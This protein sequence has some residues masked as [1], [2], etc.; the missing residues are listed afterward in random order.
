[1]VKA[2]HPADDAEDGAEYARQARPR[3][4]AA[5]DQGRYE[6]RTDENEA[7]RAH[8]RASRNGPAGWRPINL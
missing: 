6:K 1:V 2:D 3:L 5:R 7:G 8:G 4:R